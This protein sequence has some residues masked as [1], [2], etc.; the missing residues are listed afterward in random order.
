MEQKKFAMS[1]DEAAEYTGIGKNTIRQLISWKKLPVLRVGRKILIRTDS[2]E[3]LLKNNM[4]KDLRIRE[5][6]TPAE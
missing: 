6:V 5:E 4:G 3:E 2:L 1:V